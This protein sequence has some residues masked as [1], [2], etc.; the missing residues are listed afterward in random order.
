MF[1]GGGEVSLNTNANLIVCNDKCKQLMNIYKN[2]N[3]D[4]TNEV[5]EVINK[6]KLNKWSKNEFLKLRQ[7]YNDNLKN[8]AN[9]EQAVTLY[10]L[11]THAFNNQIAFNSKYEYNTP[12]G[13]SRS[14]FSKSLESKLN[15]YIKVIQNKN[16]NF[17]DYDFISFPYDSFD[18]PET[19]YYV[20]PPYLITVG[21]YE[22]DYFCKWSEEYECQLL[23]KL[24]ELNHNG[25][26]F[27]LSNVL[28][29]KGK[30]NTI[31]KHWCKKY[32]VHFLDKNYNNCNYQTKVK[33][34]NSSIEVL[35]TNY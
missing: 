11:L 1:A 3:G 10:C 12:S 33:Q 20:D 9:R 25:N 5:K 2:L 28:E 17:C 31:L 13:A 26:K 18:N 22:R 4:F 34:G 19:F 23:N 27:E 35:I 24:D 21:A 7:Y 6:W 15:E 16:I 8:T 29:H 32:N 14:Y 30:E